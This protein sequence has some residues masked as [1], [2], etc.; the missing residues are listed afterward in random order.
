M[1]GRHVTNRIKVYQVPSPSV[2]QVRLAGCA[3]SQA[4]AGNGV[5][6]VSVGAALAGA[7]GVVAPDFEAVRPAIWGVGRD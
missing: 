5:F 6:L 4:V 3:A 7:A 1:P 2:G